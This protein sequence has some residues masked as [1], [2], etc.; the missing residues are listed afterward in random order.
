MN[1]RL[2]QIII[3]WLGIL[4]VSGCGSSPTT[5]PNP[6]SNPNGNNPAPITGG[7]AP[8]TDNGLPVIDPA[9][10]QGD[11]EITGSSTVFPLTTAIVEAFVQEGSTAII[12]VRSTGT[13]TGFRLFCSGA[14]DVDIVNASRAMNAEE[15]A[16]C[17]ANNR[18]PIGFR[19]GT[20]AL[21][22]VVNNAN[23]FV[24]SLTIDQL[25]Q[26]FSGAATTW[27]DVDPT[28][29]AEP[30][31]LFSPGTDSGTF[32]YFV[33]K[34]FN[35]DPQP[36]QNAPGI[37][38]SEDDYELVKGI[39]ENPYAIG[40]FGYAY[41]QEARDQLNI[42]AID[43][44]RGT[45][46]IPDETT[47]ENGAYPLARPLYI[48]SSASVMQA[49]PHVAAFINYYLTNVNDVIRDVGYFPASEAALAE[50]RQAF[51]AAYR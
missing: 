13:V 17:M 31:A 2:K 42:V 48:Y 18:P 38:L 14:E 5:P 29:P 51:L 19:V 21:A 28:Y 25:A 40:Y 30:I 6:A 49:Q 39:V 23:D 7:A 36:I 33:E 20:D 26:I 12:D 27:S 10:V 45:A 35:K 9:E 1:V 47:V 37:L 46:V 4:L 8:T 41:Y 50:A 3:C 15:E 43:D 44:G 34:V 32:D 16:E 24:T 11:I 22:I